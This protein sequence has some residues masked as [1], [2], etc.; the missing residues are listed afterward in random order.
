M[1]K[2][3]AIALVIVKA[4][5]GATLLF[6]LPTTVEANAEPICYEDQACWDCHTMGNR[7]CGPQ[8]DERSGA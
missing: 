6:G 3:H 4:L 1:N 5:F 8:A 2:P 7:I